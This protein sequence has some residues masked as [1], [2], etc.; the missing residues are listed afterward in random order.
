MSLMLTPQC[1]LLLLLL[2]LLGVLDDVVVPL[3]HDWQAAAA[4][5]ASAGHQ[6]RKWQQI[7]GY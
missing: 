6:H 2:L 7:G 1:S 3:R 5:E 4:D